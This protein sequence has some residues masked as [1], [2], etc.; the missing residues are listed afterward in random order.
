M[1][2]LIERSRTSVVAMA[3]GAILGLPALGSAQAAAPVAEGARVYGDMCGRCH[4]P[5]SP[6]EHTDRQWVSIVNHMRVRANLT[7]DQTRA[8]LAFLQSTNADPSRAVP[9][10]EAPETPIVREPAATGEAPSM[11]PAVIERGA[12]LVEARACV[13]CHVI[14]RSG[15]QIGPS[16]NGVINRRGPDFVRRKLGDPTF[17]N[18]AS[19]M[20]NFG[21]SD[22]E[23]EAITAFLA[24][25]ERR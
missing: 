13:G 24:S 17:N 7:G 21:L 3:L 10:P 22:A 2:T 16:L 14:G 23:I 1:L 8:V 25:L 4:N 11:D 12:G 20:P 19:M 9:I 5:R 6:L 15:G 18:T